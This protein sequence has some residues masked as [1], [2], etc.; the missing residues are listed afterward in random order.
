MKIHSLFSVGLFFLLA[1]FLPAAGKPVHLFILSGQ[2]NMAHLEPSADF[3]PEAQA[4]LP[5]AG[6]ICF[7]VAVVGEPIRRWLPEWDQIAAAAQLDQSSEQGPVY[8]EQILA[9]YRKLQTR[10]PAF[11]SI[12][13]CWMQGERDAKT[14]LA[15]AYERAL[16]QLIANLRRDLRCPAMNVVIG[17]LSDHAPGPDQQADWDAVRAIQMKV[18]REIPHGAWVDTDDL[19]DKLEDGKPVNDLHYTKAGY[20][21]F[22]QRLA[23]QGVRLIRGEPPDRAGRP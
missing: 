15:A 7:K 17:R 20:A 11:A 12:T 1:G 8:Y 3:L 9:E 16:T 19:N 2:S 10:H 6:V 23:R 4:L 13:L 18:A 21:L 14:G 22:G 5:E